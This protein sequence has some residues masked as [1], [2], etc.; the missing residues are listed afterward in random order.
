M[1][2]RGKN[3][4]LEHI[5][6]EIINQ[7]AQG[8]REVIRILKEVGNF[9]TGF[10]GANAA[11]TTKWDGAP[12]VICGTD[13]SDGKFFVGT[14]SVFAITQPKIC[15]S[16]NDIQKFYDGEL[17]QK[18][19][20]SFD[21][22]GRCR[23]QGVLQGDLMFTGD[24]KVQTIQGERLVTFKPNTLVYAADADSPLG[25]QIQQAKLGI[26]FHTKYEGPT[27]AE[28]KSS[29]KI[30]KGDFTASPDAWIQTA[31]IKDIGAAASFSPTEKDRYDNAVR[32]AEGSLKQASAALNVIQSGKKTLQID[33][34]FKKFFNN[35]VK[36]GMNIPSVERAYSD[37]ERHMQ[38]EFGKAIDKLKSEAGKAKRVAEMNA[39]MAKIQQN[40]RGI[41]MIIA[42][43]MNIQSCKAMLVA[44]FQQIDSMRM[45]AMKGD[46]Y[47]CTTPEGYVAISGRSAVKL[48]DR[49]EFSNLNFQT[50]KPG[51]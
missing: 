49:L 12:A 30:N 39:M 50:G 48:I 7:G 45:F 28:M 33:T 22:L 29:F 4:H 35:Y 46:K 26:V 13:P 40:A 51:S 27:L 14:K 32:K 41:K 11:I 47:E 42:A 25:R 31:E 34:E 23:I 17:A 8:G 2:V 21:V 36:G 5:E 18:L 44:K 38:N 6:D 43:Y 16:K 37:F 3:L 10:P 9:M 20:D 24:Q 15:K 1:A 19:A